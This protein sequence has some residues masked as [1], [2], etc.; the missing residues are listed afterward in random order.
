MNKTIP[1]INPAPDGTVDL[2]DPAVRIPSGIQPRVDVWIRDTRVCLGHDG[3]YYMTG[4]TRPEGEINADRTSPDIRVWRS[5]NLDDWEDLGVVWSLERDGGPLADF[6]VYENGRGTVYTP[7]AFRR[8]V[9]PRLAPPDQPQPVNVRRS[10]WA[11]DLTWLPGR[12]EYLINFCRNTNVAVPRD[13]WTGHGLFGGNYFLRSPSG[14]PR[15][16]WTLMR[17]TPM[18]D[19]I[20]GSFFE[21]DDGSLWFIW[22][23]GRMARFTDD[24]RA[25]DLICDPWQTPF[26]PE[27]TREGPF[28]VK[29]E[30]R[31]HLFL[32]V[33]CHR[34]PDGRVSYAHE[35][36]NKGEIYSYDL[37]QCSADRLTGPYGPRYL[38][39]LGGG[40]GHP[41]VDRE[42]NWWLACFGSEACYG[43]VSDVYMPFETRC[44]P[45]IVPMKWEGERFLPSG[46]LDRPRR[47][48]NPSHSNRNPK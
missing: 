13:Q 12:G 45:Y 34:L 35:G 21:E 39:A 30:G 7:E 20:D 2:E 9:R 43:H 11:P 31:Y 46:E 28:V 37:I 48:S 19:H 29:R 41:F 36:H 25:F 14:D 1:R 3:A 16:P 8:E 32:S 27:P 22:Q 5:E 23:H 40:H 18:T 42:G 33:H 6:P 24:L 44:R 47:R 10:L 38:V 17:D 4:T 26:D 15:G